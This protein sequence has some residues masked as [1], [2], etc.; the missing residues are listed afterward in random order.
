LQAEQPPLV[1]TI[2][3]PQVVEV[4]QALLAVMVA[5]MLVV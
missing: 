1:E 2:F 3:Q 4:A 5:L